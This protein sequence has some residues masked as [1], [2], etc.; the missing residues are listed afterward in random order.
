MET[1][2]HPHLMD[3][4]TAENAIYCNDIQTQNE[5][6]LVFFFQPIAFCVI[7]SAQRLK[8]GHNCQASFAV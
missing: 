5:E 8:I 7:P 2:V 3:F 6:G 1:A 4:P